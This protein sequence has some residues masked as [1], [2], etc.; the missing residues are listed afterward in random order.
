ML[1]FLLLLLCLKMFGEEVEGNESVDSDLV[2]EVSCSVGGVESAVDGVLEG[3]VAIDSEE[4]CEF[5]GDLD[6]VN[7]CFEGPGV[8]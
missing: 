5:L 2:G 7:R 3:V 8:E 1:V 4:H 6:F